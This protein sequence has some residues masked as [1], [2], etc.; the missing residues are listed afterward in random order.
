MARLDIVQWLPHEITHHH[1]PLI[2]LLVDSAPTVEWLDPTDAPEPVT[3][4][5]PRRLYSAVGV[6]D[7]AMAET[8]EAALV[9]AC[10]G[11]RSHDGFLRQRSIE[12]LLGDLRPWTIPFVVEALGDYVIEI[13]ETLDGRVPGTLG[14]EFGHYLAANE[15]HFVTLS[16]RCVSYWNEY[17]RY[18]YESRYPLWN[19]YPGARVIADLVTAARSV[20]PDF[21]REL[22]TVL[23]RAPRR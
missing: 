14:P 6:V 4:D 3:P 1:R 7:A 15:K 10:V 12:R 5:I 8:G 22:A 11:S 17:D 16:R 19:E 20:D 13:I 23:P 9:A 18:R 21:G 2:E